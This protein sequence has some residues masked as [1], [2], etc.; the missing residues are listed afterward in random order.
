MFKI[1]LP[2]RVIKPMFSSVN[3]LFFLSSYA[4]SFL[5]SSRILPLITQD[6]FTNEFWGRTFDGGIFSFWR[7]S[8]HTHTHTHK[9]RIKLTTSAEKCFVKQKTG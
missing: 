7:Q 8:S 4:L 3:N 6:N 9:I 1:Q 5:L 2:M